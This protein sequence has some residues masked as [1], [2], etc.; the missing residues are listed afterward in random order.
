MSSLPYPSRFQILMPNSSPSLFIWLVEILLTNFAVSLD[1][2]L[3]LMSRRRHMIP[4]TKSA[5]ITSIV[6]RSYLTF[7]P[8]SF[9]FLDAT[10][11]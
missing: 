1:C 6:L 7:P 8:R 11:D 3:I 2:S 9:V 4:Q 5:D 10:Y